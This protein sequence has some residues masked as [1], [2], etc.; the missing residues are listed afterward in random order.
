MILIVCDRFPKLM[1]TDEGR[2]A[3]ERLW[4]ETMVELDFAGVKQRLAA[5]GQH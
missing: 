1:Y 5:T 3:T 2:K 4:N